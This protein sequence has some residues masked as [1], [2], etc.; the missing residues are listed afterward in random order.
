MSFDNYKP[1]VQSLGEI[2]EQIKLLQAK[3]KELEAEV[4]EAFADRGAVVLGDYQIEV[5]VQAGRK[6]FDK[7]AAMQAGLPIDD[8]MKVGK[9]FTTMSIKKVAVV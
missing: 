4:R 8:F 2:D 7:A 6:T 3:K 1:I 9:P 5:K